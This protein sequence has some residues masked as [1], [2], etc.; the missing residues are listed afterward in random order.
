MACPYTQPMVV[1]HLR[2]ITKLKKVFE[3]DIVNFI[4]ILEQYHVVRLIVMYVFMRH[5][6]HHT[7][8]QVAETQA[9]QYGNRIAW[10]VEKLIVDMYLRV[11]FKCS[12][13][14]IW[15]FKLP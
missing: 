13:Y 5:W 14:I 7:L 3:C 9:W 2:G 8:A 1:A 10:V 15:A 11:S 4:H 6:D 12:I